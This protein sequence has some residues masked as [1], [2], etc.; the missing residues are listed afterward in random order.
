PLARQAA[1]VID[2]R[3][4]LP[5]LAGSI[6][7]G[8]FAGYVFVVPGLAAVAVA[9]LLDLPLGTYLIFGA[10]IGLV[11]ALLVAFLFRQLL[12]TG[13]WDARTDIDES[14]IEHPYHPDHAA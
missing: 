4:G 9:G 10:P 14:E 1:P 13:Y 2:K 11:T 7:V 12:R 3:R 8:I 5:W 6:A